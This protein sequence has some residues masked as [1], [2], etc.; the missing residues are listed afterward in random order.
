MTVIP[1]KHQFSIWKGSTFYERITLY[2][3]AERTTLRDLNGATAVLKIKPRGDDPFTVSGVVTPL[4]GLVEFTI[5]ASSTEALTW[6]GASYELNIT[7]NGVTDTL[8]YGN[9]KV[10]DAA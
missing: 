5:S 8:L 3:D 9:I 6:K 4:S 1:A 7:K 2:S 10:L